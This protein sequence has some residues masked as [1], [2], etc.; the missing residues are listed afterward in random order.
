MKVPNENDLGPIKA[1]AWRTDE[2]FGYEH[3]RA[4]EYSL[5]RGTKYAVIYLFESEQKCDDFLAKARDEQVKLR[6]LGETA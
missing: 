5:G 3:W 1:K 6:L 2:E 4:A